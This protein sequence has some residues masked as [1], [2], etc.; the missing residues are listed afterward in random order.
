MPA[1]AKEGLVI[2][3]LSVEQCPVFHPGDVVTVCGREILCAHFNTYCAYQLSALRP[4]LKCMEK[5]LDFDHLDLDIQDGVFHCRD[6]DCSGEF[7]LNVVPATDVGII[8]GTV[9]MIQTAAGGVRNADEVDAV[10]VEEEGEAVSSVSMSSL[11]LN[12]VDDDIH[13][14]PPPVAEDRKPV[15]I[16]DAELPPRQLSRTGEKPFLR[17][18]RPD[19]ALALIASGRRNRFPA[20][21]EIL[22]QGQINDTLY[23]VRRG[24]VAIQKAMEGGAVLELAS[25]G[26]GEVF[27]E[28]S[29]LSGEEC[30][31]TV[32]TV[33]NSELVAVQ[34]EDLDIVMASN[35]AL[36]RWFSHL[37]VERLHDTDQQ[38]A[39][40][41]V[42]GMSGKLSMIGLLD[43][44]Q[45]LMIARQSGRLNVSRRMD[46]GVLYISGGQV[47]D[48]T[49]GRM[50]GEDAFYSMA[51]WTEGS[52]SFISEERS[53]IPRTVKRDTM[54]LM[55]DAAR[56]MDEGQ[57][58]PP[59]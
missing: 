58:G 19:L 29:L 34:Q 20:D 53:N 35:P 45:T 9:G 42:G 24:R 44:V 51:R 27:G 25:L 52:F 26:P 16:I 59:G 39:D 14:P 18:M 33:E 3:A 8:R 15:A 4:M 11:S 56:M 10:L 23:I 1:Y 31:A 40:R 57:G 7:E 54:H 5:E 17:R 55:M 48:A 43:V 6:Y 13:A 12:D 47:L 30:N 49:L 22:S 2:R 28:M 46:S 41:L 32:R 50:K 36:H 38:L 21:I 37:F